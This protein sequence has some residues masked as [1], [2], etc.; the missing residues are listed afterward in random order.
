MVVSADWFIGLD[1][2]TSGCRAI[3]IDANEQIVATARRA[4]PASSRPRPGWSEQSPADWWLA[5]TTVL[6]E[7]ARRG[8]RPRSL[9]IDGTSATLLL[10]NAEGQPLTN[11][12]MY[13]DR[14]ATA[15]ADRVDGFAPVDSPARGAGS[16]ISK[17]LY[18]LNQAAG[19]NAAFALH[20]AD[21]LTGCLTGR[22]GI[23]D[24][25]NVL[26]LGYDPAAG[27]WPSWFDA[28]PEVQALL[29]EVVPA[30]SPLGPINPRVADTLALPDDLLIVAGTTD[31]NAATLAAGG[32]DPGDA[33]TSLGSTLV[34]KIWSD[35]PVN[36]ARFGVYSHRLQGRW[37][38]GGASN[39]G[40]A[41]LR[42]YFS[43][44]ELVALS[45][46]IDPSRPSGLDYYPLPGVGERFPVSDPDFAPRLTPVPAEKSRF[47]QG[48]LEGIARIEANGYRRLA[49][50]GAPYPSRV[51]TAGGGAVNT[52]WRE[53]REQ[54]LGVPVSTAGQ[55]EAAFGVAGLARSA[56]LASRG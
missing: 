4:L 7:I 9:C 5:A 6:R 18:L 21:W 37:L 30:G 22:F 23:A 51:V 34:L 52:V 14:R 13:D 45:D 48:M 17:L 43:D 40:G 41:V 33:V 25:N 49:E 27:I 3:A 47:L 28:L 53:I 54:M 46:E 26:K 20:Q 42:Q 38:T 19:A 15:E 29:P 31:S 32:R 12:L 35:R 24:E 10:S 16:A 56:W 44:A 11:G 2:G 55:T 50:L 36:A 1:V 8:G 39:S